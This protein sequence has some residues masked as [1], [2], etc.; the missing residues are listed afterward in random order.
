MVRQPNV[1]LASMSTEMKK[2]LNRASLMGMQL[3]R[4]IPTQELSGWDSI[5]LD[6]EDYAISIGNEDYQAMDS[7]LDYIIN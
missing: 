3:G 6:Y 5:L 1:R 2:Y 4:G 7:A